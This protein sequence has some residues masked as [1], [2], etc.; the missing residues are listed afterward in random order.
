VSPFRAALPRVALLLLTLTALG[1]PRTVRGQDT[2][3]ATLVGRVTTEQGEILAGVEVE[4]FVDGRSEAIGSTSSQGLFRLVVPPGDV[5]LHAKSLSWVL[6]DEPTLEVAAGES[7]RVDLVLHVEPIAAEGVV[8]TGQGSNRP[9]MGGPPVMW[10]AVQREEVARRPNQGLADLVVPEPGVNVAE[11]GLQGRTLNTRGFSNIFTGAT[12]FLVD[13]REAA[14]PSLRADFTHFVPTGVHDVQRMEVVLGP[15]TAVYGPNAA[16]GVVHV[17]TRS[18]LDAPSTFL[19]LTGGGQ[20][21][22]QGRFRSN[23]R[24]GDGLG[25]KI[26]GEGFQGQ[27]YGYVDPVEEAI[28]MEI[29]TDLEGYAQ[30]LRDRGVPEEE[31]P[32]RMARTG[33]RDLDLERWRLE[34]RVD[35]LVASDDTLV[36]QAGTSSNTGIELTPLGAAQAGSWRYSYAQARYHGGPLFAQLYINTSDAGDSYLLRDGAPLVDNSRAIGLQA[37]HGLVFSN[38]R[39]ELSYG[40]DWLST[41]PRTGGTIH[42]QFEDEDGIDEYGAYLQ[43]RLGL[44]ES[45]DLIATGRIDESNVIA[46]PVFSPRVGLVLQP[47]PGRSFRISLARGFSTPTPTNTFLDIAAGRAPGDLGGLGYFTRARGTGRDGIHFQQPDGSYVMRSPFSSVEQ[48]GPGALAPVTA[49]ELWLRAVN[50]LEGGGG[51]DPATAAF[52][53]GLD[54]TGQVGVNALDPLSETIAPLNQVGVD[55][56]RP[57]EETTTTTLE[58]GY[59]G[60]LGD[61]IVVHTGLWHTWRKNF[62]SPPLPRTPLLLLDGVA[63]GQFLASSGLPPEQAELLATNV[64]SAPLG[65]V[66][67][68]DIQGMGAEVVASY[69]NYG[70]LSY[71]GGDIGFQADLDRRWSLDGSFSWVSDDHFEV[72][73]ELVTL[74]APEFKATMGLGFTNL[75]IPLSGEVRLRH[76]SGFPAQSGDFEALRCLPDHGS[77]LE[78]CVDSATLVDLSLGYTLPF[79]NAAFRLRARNLFDTPY[80]AF[81]GSPTTGL[82]LSAQVDWTI[83]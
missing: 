42:G 72:E 78:D 21:L 4:A 12:L 71:W 7:H 59:Q 57:L 48:G 14:L 50:L 67:S 24:L 43:G 25:L 55:D 5:Q 52:L 73:D 17:L 69:V 64:G 36:F 8:V 3:D 6:R 29:K 9:S 75:P 81:P 77:A 45:L 33:I 54:P 32:G 2:R 49:Q 41:T 53:R 19:S 76:H 79:E 58:I 26:S 15:T 13:Y 30:R 80:R 1:R 40:A 38:G 37:R 44:T 27:E 66:S 61:R 82:L 34:G 35:A 65:V 23:F 51:V 47:S 22:T 20:S 28:R 83:R 16:D 39:H 56:I 10:S 60:L 63:L 68:N 74:N 62:V 70:D 18:S 46:D 31:I 11:T